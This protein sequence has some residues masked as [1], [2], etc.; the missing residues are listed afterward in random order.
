VVK[1]IT[2]SGATDTARLV[3]TISNPWHE[4]SITSIIIGPASHW[5][6]AHWKQQPLGSDPINSDS[7]RITISGIDQNG[8]AFSFPALTGIHPHPDS[9]PNLSAVIDAKI[10]PGSD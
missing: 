4:G 5:F 6:S 3:H 2:A 7:V 10:F 8:N 9:I 1:E